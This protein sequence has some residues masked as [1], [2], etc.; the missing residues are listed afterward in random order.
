MLTKENSMKLMTLNIWGGHVKEPLLQF[1]NQQK[2][3]DIICLQ[4]VYHDAV[5]KFS[6]DEKTATL[7][8]FSELNT[9]LQHHQSLFKPVIGR[10]NG[11]A[12]GICMFVKKG[13]EILNEGDIL[14]HHNPD[15]P[16]DVPNKKGPRHSRNLQWIECRRKDEGT[17]TVMNIH[18]L[19]NGQGKS[20][21]QERIAQSQ[22]IRKFMD[23]VTTPKILCGD[24]N[25]R[26]ETQS[27]KIVEK[28]MCNLVEKYQISTT[29]TTLYSKREEEPFADY[30]FTC[31]DISIN[32]FQVLP[33]VVSD[34]AP[35]VLDFEVN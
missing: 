21:T 1:I 12:Y 18:G 33:D 34:H 19:W 11:N 26:P 16:A 6:T 2:H 5:N 8:I 24:F 35:L 28:G 23:Q 13:I 25:L 20:D 10:A 30:I 14:I 7:N 15:Y 27:L 3:L 29:R 17:F 4:E 9:L 31:P 32:T 22:S